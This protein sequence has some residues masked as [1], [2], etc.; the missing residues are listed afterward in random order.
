LLAAVAAVLSAV[1]AV[2][3]VTFLLPSQWVLG[4][5]MRLLLALAGLVLS[6]EALNPKKAPT[7]AIRCLQ[8]LQP[9]SAGVAGVVTLRLPTR[10]TRA[11]TGAAAGALA[12]KTQLA[13][14]VLEH[15]AKVMPEDL[16]PV[17]QVL[18]LAAAAAVLVEQAQTEQAVSTES[19]ELGQL[20]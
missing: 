3:A 10:R 12:T 17:P 14:R 11:I 18:Q 4:K 15:L 1:A 16:L 9:P 2:L 13:L 7:A 6:T 19:A 20:G 8:V 5:L